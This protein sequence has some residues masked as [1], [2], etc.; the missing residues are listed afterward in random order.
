[1]LE[2][3]EDEKESG[4]RSGWVGGVWGLGSEGGGAGWGGGFEDIGGA[5]EDLLERVEA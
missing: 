3:E 5:G 4:S 1:M 2:E